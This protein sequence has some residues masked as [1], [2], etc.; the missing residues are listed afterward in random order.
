MESFAEITKIKTKLGTAQ[1]N[2]KKMHRMKYYHKTKRK[3]RNKDSSG[4]VISMEVGNDVHA[5]YDYLEGS[6][7][8]EEEDHKHEDQDDDEH[9]SE[10]SANETCT[11]E[12]NYNRSGKCRLN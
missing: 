1:H 3:T 12:K 4:N 11:S 7:D 10:E 5:N 8:T 6:M 2:L 9:S